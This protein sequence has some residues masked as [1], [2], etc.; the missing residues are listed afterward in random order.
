MSK[1]NHAPV[2][3]SQNYLTSAKTI[4]RLINKTS[5]S[6]SDHIVE[7]GPGKGHI[8]ALLL[9]RCQKLSAVEIDKTL[10]SKLQ[11]KFENASNLKL[12]CH[13]FVKWPLPAGPYKI[14]ANIPFN[15]TTDII[16]KLAGSKNPPAEAWLI[17]EKG[18]AKRFMGVPRENAL[19]LT[20]KP[21]Y[22]MC[23]AYHFRREDF[24]PMPGVDVVMLHMK[25]KTPW[26]IPLPQLVRYQRFI[27]TA[28][29]N[30]GLARV[31]TK[32]QLSKARR[33]AGLNDN[34]SA[35]ILYIQWLCLFRCCVMFARNC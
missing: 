26:D 6:A 31:F 5:I 30:G 27:S 14:F 35:E 16:R 15:R 21:L 3:V 25:Q 18:A 13:D 34:T 8:T 10:H 9:R 1:N 19:S 20:I 4:Q 23:I 7:I 29:K 28:T 17:M 32:K 2:W 22:D 12:Y 24:H 33:E 11:T